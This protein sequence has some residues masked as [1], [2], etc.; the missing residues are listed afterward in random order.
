VQATAP[1]LARRLPPVAPSWTIIG[2]LAPY[3]QRRHR[4]PPARVVVWSGDNPCSLVGTGLVVE[5]RVAISLGTSDTIFGL[6]RALPSG[7]EGRPEGHIF[8]SP[9]GDVMGMTVFKN[10]SLARERMRDAYG[11]D[12]LQFSAA[13]RTTLPGNGGALM[14][15]WFDPEITP[16][17]STPSVRRRGLSEADGASNVRAIVEAQM[18]AMAN[19]SSWMGAP[20]SIIHATGGGSVNDEILQVM[21]DVFQ[22]D[23]YRLG[24]GNSASLGAALRAWHA[25]ARASDQ[26]VDWEDIVRDFAAPD[27]ATRVRPRTEL[28]QT[29]RDLRKRYAAFESEALKGGS[30]GPGL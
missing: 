12:W 9:T 2:T 6:M 16:N 20:P 19:H 30:G 11:L 4:L 1:D 15:P 29:Y 13:L 25:N 28:A 10:G 8:A 21:A 22:A 7:D 14:L 17:V 24:S 26:P 27:P 3:W 18:M 5:G 23:V